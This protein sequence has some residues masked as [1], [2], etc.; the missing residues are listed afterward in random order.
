MNVMT[1]TLELMKNMWDSMG[2]SKM[3]MP[4]MVMP[5]LSVE[6]IDKQIKDLKAVEAWLNVNMGML[7]G[8]IQALE[9][10]SATLSTLQSMGQSMSAAVSANTA[11]ASS[12]S[13]TEST[14][15]AGT[16]PTSS[17]ESNGA[18]GAT[19]PASAGTSNF[20]APFANPALWWNMLQDQFKQVVNTTMTQEESVNKSAA[21]APQE[22]VK[23]TPPTKTPQRKRKAPPKA[24]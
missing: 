10:Q 2:A 9:V 19:H 3:S 16:E 6:E 5:T 14:R 20:T 11:S 21:S 1:D 8:T 24:S 13:K 17:S 22:V 12:G 15:K 18:A 4:G 23:P 7:R